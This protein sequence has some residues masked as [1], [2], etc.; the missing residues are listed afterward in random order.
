MVDPLIFWLSDPDS[1]HP[2]FQSF[3]ADFFVRFLSLFAGGG[4]N[5]ARIFVT[6]LRSLG[7]VPPDFRF[8]GF[9]DEVPRFLG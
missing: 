3:W 1:C 8:F 4:V 7:E 5:S 2:D 9:L 6:F